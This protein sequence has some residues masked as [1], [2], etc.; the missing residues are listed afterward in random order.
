MK[1]KLVLILIAATLTL[2]S[3]ACGSK[4][5]Q[6]PAE[7]QQ[8][9][10]QETEPVEQEEEEESEPET[11]EPEESAEPESEPEET[12]E[13]TP[14]ASMTNALPLTVGETVSGEVERGKSVWYTFTAS[15]KESVYNVILENTT[16]DGGAYGLEIQGVLRDENGEKIGSHFNAFD[17]G[18]I[19]VEELKDLKPNTTYYVHLSLT[20][21]VDVNGD[22]NLTVKEVTE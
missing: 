7:P 10:Q 20:D 9:E 1:K 22:Y 12:D 19:E 15:D 11:T 21:L 4:P 13:S 16:T 18:K 6:E 2:A 5:A 14:G 17:D 8:Q 3:T